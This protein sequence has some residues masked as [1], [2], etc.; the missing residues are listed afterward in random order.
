VVIISP[1]LDEHILA[2]PYRV[3]RTLETKVNRAMVL[4][5]HTSANTTN[6]GGI[7]CGYLR[8]PMILRRGVKR[9]ASGG[10]EKAYSMEMNKKA[11]ELK[12]ARAGPVPTNCSRVLDAVMLKAAKERVRMLSRSATTMS[13]CQQKGR[14]DER[15]LTERDKPQQ[16]EGATDKLRDFDRIHGG[17]V[18]DGETK[19]G[20][21]GHKERNGSL[22]GI[23]SEHQRKGKKGGRLPPF[24]LR[25][26][27]ASWGRE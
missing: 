21:C 9:G 7:A 27:A 3:D 1:G 15:Q 13:L 22:A 16:Q 4:V 10:S 25:S 11:L 20:V 5:Q 2:G 18:V 24:L 17:R 12:T 23:A 6:T 8:S 19:E 14:D 26:R